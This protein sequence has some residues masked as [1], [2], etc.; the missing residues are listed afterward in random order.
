MKKV[1]D[2]IRFIVEGKPQP[3][4]SMKAY[5]AKRVTS[6]N[7]H[8]KAWT[9]TAQWLAKEVMMGRDR[10]AGPL[11]VRMLATFRRPKSMPRRNPHKLTPP[12]VDKLARAALD[13]MTGIVYGDDAQ[14]VYLIAGKEFGL[15][16]QTVIEVRQL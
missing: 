3:K 2:Q 5:S 10:F 15:I 8:L 13:A 1:K 9:Q 6:A 7:P 12:D 14:V 16:E 4:G 11:S